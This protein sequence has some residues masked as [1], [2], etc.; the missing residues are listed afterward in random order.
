MELTQAK[1][2]PGRYT[3]FVKAVAKPSLMN[4]ISNAVE[5]G[6]PETK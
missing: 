3:F 2:A 5:A 1:L 6:I 4:H